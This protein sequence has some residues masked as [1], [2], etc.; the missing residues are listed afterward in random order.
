MPDR[1]SAIKSMVAMPLAAALANPVFPCAAAAMLRTAKTTTAGGKTVYAALAAPERKKPASVLL[2]H[3]WWGLNGQMKAVAEEFASHGFN[4]LAVDL[5]GGQVATDA[6]SARALTRA[7]NPKLA[8]EIL[9]AWVRWLRTH[10]DG[11]GKI[12][13]VGWSFGGGWSLNASLA[14]PVDATVVYYGNVKR[15]EEELTNLR[16]P[17][18]GHFADHDP[19]IDHEMVSGFSDAMYRSGKDLVAHWY[20]AQHAFANPSTSRYDA[21]DARL[22]WTRTLAF[23]KEHLAG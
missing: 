8:T 2:I 18:L 3:E 9:V 6:G 19:W 12:G 4:A 7:V 11:N 21:R 10:P 23:L 20:D 13:V 1:R 17:V 22:A 14:T 16:G 5:F 15:T